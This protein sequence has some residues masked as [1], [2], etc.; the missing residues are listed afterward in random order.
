VLDRQLR[1]GIIPVPQSPI[2]SSGTT[3]PIRE[4]SRVDIELQAGQSPRVTF[5][6]TP[7]E[8]DVLQLLVEGQ[9]DAEIAHALG[10]SPRTVSWYVGE[11]LE[12]TG[13]S[14]RVALA[15]CAIRQGLID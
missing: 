5:R 1:I 14:S 6:L 4:G 12:R 2:A 13:L 10:L 3:A 8:R 9:G 11:M 7:R 15:V